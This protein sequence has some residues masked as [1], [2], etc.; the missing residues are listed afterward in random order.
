MFLLVMATVWH[1]DKK[2]PSTV[3]QSSP[4]KELGSDPLVTA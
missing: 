3:F 2:F 1:L 4:A